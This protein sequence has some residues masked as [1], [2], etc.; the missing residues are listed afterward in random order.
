M[1]LEGNRDAVASAAAGIPGEDR[2][3]TSLRSGKGTTHIVGAGLAGLAA[4]VHLSARGHQVRV[5]EAAG[6]AGGRCRSYYDAAFGGV[7]DNGNHLLLSGNTSAMNYLKLIGGADK[8]AGPP[9]AE[10]TFVDLA[11]G[12]HWNL[13]IN[14][15]RWP[16]WLFDPSRRVP[17]TNALDYL[18]AARLIWVGANKRISDVIHPQGALY[19]R[20]WHPLFLAALNTDP[21]EGSARLAGAVMRETLAKGGAACRPLVAEGLS[22]AFIEPAIDYLQARGNA[23]AFGSR[24]RDI[25]FGS[26]RAKTL[27]IGE[28]NLV[29]IAEG[30]S[31]IV[32]V[33][34]WV[35][36]TLVPGLEVPCEYR[37]ILNA[38]YRI[39]P[40]RNCPKILGVINGTAEWIFAFPNRLSLTISGADRLMDRPREDL[41][42]SLWHEV[43]QVTGLPAELPPWQ[44]VKEK[45]A[46]FA[47]TPD[48]DARRPDTKTRWRNLFLA[49]DWIQTG[50]PAT[51]EGAIQ[52][53]ERAAGMVM[54]RTVRG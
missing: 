3:M 23:I 6:Q 34:P 11:S 42:A 40:P 37:A 43:S 19:A 41:A 38:H 28:G 15:G 10:F 44:I 49:G 7:I 25:A 17:D 13:K 30:D 35:A 12:G 16:S 46:T 54:K 18:A 39:E 33:P 9:M 27:S 31:I 36:E 26:E 1:S 45:R 29:E 50:L 4:A 5:Y 24:V 51:I 20:L 21:Q 14:E 52:S 22:A 53:G 8:L 2:S 47:A 48:Q 32:A